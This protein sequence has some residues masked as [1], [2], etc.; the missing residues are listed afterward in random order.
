MVEDIEN[1]IR[2]S[3]RPENIYNVHILKST[4]SFELWK[5]WMLLLYMGGGNRFR[6]NV[7]VYFTVVS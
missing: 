4:S 5:F 7:Y 3:T 1:V 6:A 2:V